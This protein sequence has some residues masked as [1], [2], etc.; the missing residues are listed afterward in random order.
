M[1]SSVCGHARY[2][3][4]REENQSIHINLF[5]LNAAPVLLSDDEG[6]PY[7]VV[8]STL[9][10]FLFVNVREAVFGLSGVAFGLFLRL[11]T[12]KIK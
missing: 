10:K 9:I 4:H 1:V 7:P 11:D 3:Q 5:Q 2:T 12:R 6:E 8:P